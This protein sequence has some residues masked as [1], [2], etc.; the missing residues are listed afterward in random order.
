MKN[1]PRR[2]AAIFA[3]WVAL[4]VSGVGIATAAKADTCYCNA[5]GGP[6]CSDGCACYETSCTLIS[7]NNGAQPACPSVQDYTDCDADNACAVTGGG[8]DN[9]DDG[10]GQGLEDFL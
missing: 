2:S 4:V 5:T 7:N 8:G 1:T 6:Y 3:A 10:Y 9:G